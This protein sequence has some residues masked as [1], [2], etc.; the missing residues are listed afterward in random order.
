MYR[1]RNINTPR[2]IVQSNDPIFSTL[3]S[4]QDVP[5][6]NINPSPKPTFWSGTSVEKNFAPRDCGWSECGAHFENTIYFLKSITL[7]SLLLD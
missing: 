1:V 2:L 6:P 5:N 3:V 4:V 7:F